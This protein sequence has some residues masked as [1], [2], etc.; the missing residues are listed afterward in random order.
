MQ[1][2]NIALYRD[3]HDPGGHEG[4]GNSDIIPAVSQGYTIRD[5]RLPEDE[6]AAVSF[7]AGLQKYE[8]E[9][10]PNRRIDPRVGADYFAV[11]MRRIASH[12]GRVFVAEQNGIAVGWAVFLVE[13]E[14]IYIVEKERRAAVV[15]ELFVAENVR[16][17]GIGKSLLASCEA[18]AR[19]RGANVLMIGVVQKNAQARAV[20]LATGFSPYAEVL[21]KH[22]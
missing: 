20:Y 15:A 12:E 1:N 10:E 21:R 17:I 19:R 6:A 11:L 14:P 16:G 4:E 22:L 9:F 3:F 18:E 5:L 7:I 13:E 8:R 2:L